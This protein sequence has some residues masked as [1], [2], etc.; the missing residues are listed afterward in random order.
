LFQKPEIRRAIGQTKGAKIFLHQF[1]SLH[2][3]TRF[4]SKF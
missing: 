3:A 4:P 2:C 1:V